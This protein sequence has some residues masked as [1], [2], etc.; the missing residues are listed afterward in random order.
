M[1]GGYFDYKQHNIQIIAED[2]GYVIGINNSEEIDEFGDKIAPGFSEETIALFI[3]AE[4]TLYKAY[5]MAQRID[6]L[7]SG[8]DG[9]AAF[10]AKWKKELYELYKLNTK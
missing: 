6:W 1:S 5:I 7:V 2:I 4:E 3:E 8:D 9:E 10:H